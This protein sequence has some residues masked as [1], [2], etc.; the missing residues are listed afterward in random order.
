MQTKKARRGF[1]ELS[2]IGG[3]P[4]E[5]HHLSDLSLMERAEELSSNLLTGTIDSLVIIYH[6]T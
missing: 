6:L 1:A 4:K 5:T 3:V 2:I